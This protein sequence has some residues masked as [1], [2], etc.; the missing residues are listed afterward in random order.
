M[1]T[2]FLSF[3]FPPDLSAGSF[4]ATALV[5]SLLKKNPKTKVHV[6]TTFPNRYSDYEIENKENILAHEEKD[7]LII[8][9]INLP[10]FNSGFIG[11]G[12]KR[13]SY[14][15]RYFKPSV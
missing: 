13:Y 1:S 12:A 8:H 11:H 15:F 2:I 3:Y 9:R 10:R 6:V 7:N 14:R 4:R 5:D